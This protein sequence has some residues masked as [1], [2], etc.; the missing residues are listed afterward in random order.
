MSTTTTGFALSRTEIASFEENGHL[1]PFPTFSPTE[2]E[3]VRRGVDEVLSDPTPFNSHNGQSRH[4]DKRVVWE[5]CSHPAI[6]ERMASIKGPD[7][8]LWRSNFFTKH[9]G[10]KEIPW[11]QDHN[12]WPL[13]PKI[14]LTAWV[15]IDEVTTENSCVQILPGTHRKRVPHVRAGDEMAFQEMADMNGIDLNSKI[16]MELK[17]GEFFLFNENTLHHSEMNRSQ[18]RRCGL[19]VRVTVPEVRVDHDA[20]FEGHR[21]ILLCGEDRYGH[22]RMA[23]P[24][25]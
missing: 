2:M 15:A 13:D 1:G 14:N 22:N 17:P 18:K 3:D 6:V 24:P 7:L 11:H 12:Y 4:L 20:L 10:D 19:A 16:N 25:L 9:P 21:C 23:G 5:L 8:V